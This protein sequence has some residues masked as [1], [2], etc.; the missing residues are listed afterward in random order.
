MTLAGCPQLAVQQGT[1]LHAALEAH[2]S[3]DSSSKELFQA[4]RLNLVIS[5]GEA[6]TTLTTAREA[7]QMLIQ[8]MPAISALLLQLR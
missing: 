6:L 1:R 7:Q 3:T 2:A 8:V 4:C 5:T